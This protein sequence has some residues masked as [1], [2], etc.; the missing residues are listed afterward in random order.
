MLATV[1]STLQAQVPEAL[2]LRLETL[3]E[4]S[5]NTTLVD[6]WLELYA[7]HIDNPININDTANDALMGL[8][9][10]S[11]FQRQALSAYLRQHG[12]MVS[13]YE[14]Y[15][16]NGFDTLTLS[17]LLPIVKA[18]PMES[19][20]RPSLH[21]IL[22]HGSSNLVAGLH[23][24]IEPARGYRDTIY[25]GNPLRL[26]Y[27]YC[28]K[29]KD[30]VQL[31]LSA[32]K[33]PGEA[34][35]SGSQPRGFDFYGGHLMLNNF[36]YLQRAIV[37][38]YNLQFGQ[39]LTLWSGFAP[40]GGTNANIARFA[41]GIR[42]ASAF[43]EYGYLQGIATTIALAP[44]CNITVFYSHV[45]R[46]ATPSAT[47]S[48]AV[49]SISHSG[50]HRT[51]TEINKRGQLGES[52]YGIHFDYE[53]S[54]LR[55][56]L[57]ATHTLLDK[58]IVPSE[59]P[60]NAY[61]FQGNRLTNGGIDM[62]WR[63]GQ[64][65]LFGEA[66]YALHHSTAA[67]VGLQFYANSNHHIGITYRNYGKDYQNLHAAPLAQ[68]SRH[69][70]EE[71]IMIAYCAHLPHSL[72]LLLSS[73]IFR[74][75]G[76][77]YGI[78]APSQG[79]EQR[80]TL[81]IPVAKRNTLHLRYRYKEL[82]HNS[83]SGTAYHIEQTYRNQLQADLECHPTQQ[84]QMVS[85]IGYCWFRTSQGEAQQGLLMSQDLT[86]A[87]HTLPLS[88]SARI[89]LFDIDDYDARLYLVESDMV[90][91]QSTPSYLDQGL[92]GYLVVRYEPTDQL[93]IGAKY[94]ITNYSNRTTVGS[95]YELI[96]A[97]HRQQ[98]KVQ[99]RWKIRHREAKRPPTHT[100]GY[101]TP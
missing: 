74:H 69:Q 100:A 2:R 18:N 55:I 37:G 6:E 56:G 10:I 62:A 4:Q 87:P 14:L 73:D 34:L 31:Q 9:F 98:W 29:Y 94:A 96:E 19:S 72:Q 35:F 17:L 36:G 15:A 75:N 49:Q 28:F 48:L 70:Q 90:Y 95:G 47:D 60:Y 38:Q 42:P 50:Y 65:L 79:N 58:P 11:D 71:G 25:E 81:S 68:N 7:Y 67:I 8:F 24:S 80:A 97:S 3:A 92:R 84:L 16:V 40:Y 43:A 101:N 59:T 27:R 30:R 77:R 39:G 86:W 76:L 32:D 78:Y 51:A 54:S 20:R 82:P 21:D 1:F 99:L 85:R 45:H 63:V 13:V 23:S 46:D 26:Y 64:L 41:Q 44:H 89:A 53:Q 88:L 33:D 12:E 91:E 22:Y 83:N 93:S 66:S 5:D 57:T 61:A 52:L